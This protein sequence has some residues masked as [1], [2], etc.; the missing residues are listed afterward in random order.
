[1]SIKTRTEHGKKVV[2]RV[3]EAGDTPVL[4]NVN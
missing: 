2:T 3:R 1:V 4:T